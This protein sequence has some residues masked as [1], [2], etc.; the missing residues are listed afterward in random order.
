MTLFAVINWDDA[1]TQTAIATGILF[2]LLLLP[3]FIAAKML[4]PRPTALRIFATAVLQV[5]FV[6]GASFVVFTLLVLGGAGVSGFAGLF[7]FILSAL[8]TA[9]IY[10]FGF[11]KGVVYNVLVVLLFAGIWWGLNMAGQAGLLDPLLGKRASSPVAKTA[12][13]QLRRF[14]TVK[15]AQDAALSRYPD[16]G[17]AGSPFNQRFVE[18]HKRYQTEKPDML[19][20]ADWPWRLAQ[21][22]AAELGTP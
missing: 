17:V 10:G 3:H 9:G 14:A 12:E 4:A 6:F 1:Q 20:S 16:L 13:D 19:A 15:E 8:V 7:V 22:V 18:K 2:L 11:G 21:E 5:I